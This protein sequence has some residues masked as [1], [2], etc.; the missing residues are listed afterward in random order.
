MPSSGRFN[1]LNSGDLSRLIVSPLKRAK[2]L[3]ATWTT[4]LT[5]WL[6]SRKASRI[7][8]AGDQP[9]STRAITPRNEIYGIH[10]PEVGKPAAD[11]H[12][13]PSMPAL[14]LDLVICCSSRLLF[15]QMRSAVRLPV[16]SDTRGQ[17]RNTVLHTPCRK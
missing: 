12:K 10:R 13:N 3:L 4:P 1:V 5:A 16:R 8:T 17:M 6:C 14:F 11:Y 9:F 7:N 2:E 15:S